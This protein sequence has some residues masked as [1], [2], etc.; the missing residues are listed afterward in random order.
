LQLLSKWQ[1]TEGVDFWDGFHKHTAI[2][3]MVTPKQQFTFENDMN[4]WGVPTN[5]IIENVEQTFDQERSANF[6]NQRAAG[7]TSNFNRFWTLDEVIR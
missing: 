7:N 6:L 4:R 5:V 1:Q 2:R 3:I